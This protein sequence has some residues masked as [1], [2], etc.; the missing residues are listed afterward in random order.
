MYQSPY[1]SQSPWTEV[2]PSF[3][4]AQTGIRQSLSTSFSTA[5]RDH[6]VQPAGQGSSARSQADANSLITA[7]L[8]GMP[9]DRPDS[10][11]PLHS[12]FPLA[13][14][15]SSSVVS[16][17]KHLP[18]AASG[19]LKCPYEV[20]IA[21]S[22]TWNLDTKTLYTHQDC[23]VKASSRRAS[24]TK[25]LPSPPKSADTSNCTVCCLQTY[26]H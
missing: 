4:V 23:R 13:R 9:I 7:A 19:P 15:S 26:K 20:M 22:S 24:L 14:M 18:R 21:P 12:P 16:K 8:F 3:T 6:V 25:V 10:L 11:L 5:C 2:T 1:R 17:F